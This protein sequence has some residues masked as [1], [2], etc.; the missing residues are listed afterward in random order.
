MSGSEQQCTAPSGKSS[1][2]YTFRLGNWQ[3]SSR[4][5][6][7]ALGRDLQ[8]S[9]IPTGD[10]VVVSVDGKLYSLFYLYICGTH[11]NFEKLVA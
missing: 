10:L 1:W 9:G 11:C 2:N 5:A 4:L 6:T 7:D 3:E 8:Q